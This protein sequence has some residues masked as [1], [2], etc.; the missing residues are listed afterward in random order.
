MITAPHLLVLLYTVSLEHQKTLA[1]V[2]YV[3][4]SSFEAYK[5]TLTILFENKATVSLLISTVVN[6]VIKVNPGI[7]PS[8]IAVTVGLFTG[9]ISIAISLL[10]LGIL[11]DFIP[12]KA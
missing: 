12:G 3:C 5:L 11:V 1:L 4:T 10:R 7:T 8:E 2:P 6:S 9:I